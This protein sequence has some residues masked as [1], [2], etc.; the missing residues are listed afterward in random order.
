MPHGLKKTAVSATFATNP[1]L[2]SNLFP[3][4]A[5]FT[6]GF[7]K[8]SPRSFTRGLTTR[9]AAVLACRSPAT[10]ESTWI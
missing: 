7:V 5:I 6:V 2:T 10:T 3:A 9:A 1:A 4:A 8:N